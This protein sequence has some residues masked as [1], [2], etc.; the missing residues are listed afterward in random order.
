[1]ELPEYLTFVSDR[2]K[3]LQEQGNREE[4]RRVI[5]TVV[6]TLKDAIRKMDDVERGSE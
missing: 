1:M 4:V 2:L 3:T 5:G 6:D